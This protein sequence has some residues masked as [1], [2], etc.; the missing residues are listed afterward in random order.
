M[1][2]LSPPH[3]IRRP[4]V[5]SA[6]LDDFTITIVIVD[7][8]SMGDH[9]V[10]DLRLHVSLPVIDVDIGSLPGYVRYPFRRNPPIDRDERD[11]V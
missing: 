4:P 10:A 2:V 8:R 5:G 11:T 7:V 3:E 6:H 9:S 1:P